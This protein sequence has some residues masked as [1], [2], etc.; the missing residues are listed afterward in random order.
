MSAI[1]RYVYGGEADFKN[2]LFGIQIYKF[3]HNTQINSLMNKGLIQFFGDKIK[4]SNC[5]AIFKVFH[6]YGD[7]L[8][9]E[10]CKEVRVF[11]MLYLKAQSTGW[12]NE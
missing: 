7:K 9:L 3:A 1:F 5:F 12:D 2:V 4:T 11:V 10:L 6:F 8:G